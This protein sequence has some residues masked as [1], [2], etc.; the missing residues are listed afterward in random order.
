MD[1]TMAMEDVPHLLTLPREVRDNIYSYLH[2]EVSRHYQNRRLQLK[3]APIVAVLLTHSQLYHEYQDA[4][5]YKD[6]HCVL[7]S[8]RCKDI[9]RPK[10]I[11]ADSKVFSQISHLDLHVGLR[12]DPLEGEPG[13]AMYS[14]PTEESI[15][16]KIPT[17][18][19]LESSIPKPLRP[20]LPRLKTLRFSTWHHKNIRT[21]DISLDSAGYRS[22]SVPVPQTIHGLKMIQ[23]ANV[24][25]FANDADKVGWHVIL[26][27]GYY[28]YANTTAKTSKANF[29]TLAEVADVTVATYW[30]ADLERF[31]KEREGI[32]AVLAA[33]VLGW[34]DQRMA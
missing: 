13:E 9:E 10:A 25:R 24:C 22:K 33:K 30:P 34:T 21:E 19:S 16:H 5:C 15:G 23:V 3:N 18:Q 8:S 2:H 31:E 17:E 12:S 29:W 26:S 6:L 20:M 7:P 32:A 14:H 27:E 1:S 4:D 28:L 11:R